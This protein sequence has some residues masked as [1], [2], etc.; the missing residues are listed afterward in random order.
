VGALVAAVALL[1]VVVLTGSLGAFVR[2]TRTRVSKPAHFVEVWAR[3]SGAL[4]GLYVAQELIEGLLVAGHPTGVAGLVG[5]GGWTV[6]LVA[7]T[8]AALLTL[9]VRGEHATAALAASPAAHAGRPR[10]V[11]IALP[12]LALLPT[13]NGVARHLAGRG[14]PPLTR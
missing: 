3:T 4:L 5:H 2:G 6:L 12:L 9:V 13:P 14:P 11:T 10:P 7:P 1:L 8:V